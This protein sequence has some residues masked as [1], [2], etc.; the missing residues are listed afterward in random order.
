[1][2]GEGDGEVLVRRGRGMLGK[3]RGWRIIGV[4]ADN[5]FK[6]LIPVRTFLCVFFGV[7]TSVIRDLSNV[8]S[9]VLTT[10]RDFPYQTK[11]KK[12]L[13]GYHTLNPMPSTLLTNIHVTPP[14]LQ[15]ILP[16]S[17]PTNLTPVAPAPKRRDPLEMTGMRALMML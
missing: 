14:T 13:P 5:T 16:M 6:K 1:M 12:I 7:L 8:S 17:R 11:S 10:R 3:G 2:G 9:C 4:G 15:N